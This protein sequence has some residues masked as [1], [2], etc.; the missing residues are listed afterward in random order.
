MLSC[1][2]IHLESCVSFEGTSKESGLDRV[3]ISIMSFKKATHFVNLHGR[4]DEVRIS[5]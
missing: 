5:G 4:L 2:S 1:P 3:T